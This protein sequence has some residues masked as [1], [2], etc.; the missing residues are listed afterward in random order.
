MNKRLILAL[1]V[2]FTAFPIVGPARA[3][4]GYGTFTMSF[5]DVSLLN[6]FTPYQNTTG[7][8][9]ITNCYTAWSDPGIWFNHKGWSTDIAACDNGREVAQIRYDFGGRVVDLQR[10]RIYTNSINWNEINGQGKEPVTLALWHDGSFTTY[11]P[12]FH[13]NPGSNVSRVFDI[14]VTGGSLC[15][16]CDHTHL[17]DK[18]ELRLVKDATFL[19]NIVSYPTYIYYV[20]IT[21]TYGPGTVTPQPTFTP[22]PTSTTILTPYPTY[23]PPNTGIPPTATPLPTAINT[24]VAPALSPVATVDTCDPSNL[25]RACGPLAIFPTLFLPTVDLPSPTRIAQV[26]SPTPR[27]ITATP[28]GTLSPTPTFT[29]TS[30]VSSVTPIGSPIATV[31]GGGAG[32]DVSGIERL[33]Q[34]ARDTLATFTPLN[35]TTFDLNGTPTGLGRTVAELGKLIAQPI[36]MFRSLT[37]TDAN[38]GAGL[39]DFG[40]LVLIFIILIEV[41]AFVLPLLLSIFKVVLQLI[42]TFKPF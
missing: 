30:L 11:G 40:L 21:Y 39:I 20:E 23:P 16:W 3:Q 41:G 5:Q 32:I 4:V 27:Q 1:L 8:A 29:A 26:S 42:Q 31:M 13:T 35:D 2:L 19:G 12:Y 28:S 37:G 6:G 14:D 34:F 24:R 33:S 22:W 36:R 25:A 17:T 18:F 7:W 15:G 10:V 9:F 38:K